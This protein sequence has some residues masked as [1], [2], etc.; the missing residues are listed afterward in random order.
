MDDIIV[1][2]PTRWQPRRAVQKCPEFHCLILG[3]TPHSSFLF[4]DD[5][6]HELSGYL[7]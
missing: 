4:H 3:F 7:A 6:P 1:L 5:T 2:P